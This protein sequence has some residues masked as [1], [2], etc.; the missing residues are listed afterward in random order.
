ME[1]IRGTA[2]KGSKEVGKAGERNVLETKRRKC[3]Q[4]K[5]MV[6]SVK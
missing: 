1:N 5:E 3:S 6:N 2:M 4:N